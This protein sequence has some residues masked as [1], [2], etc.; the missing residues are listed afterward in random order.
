METRG[1]FLFKM[2]I[3]VLMIAAA[4]MALAVIDDNQFEEVSEAAGVSYIGPSWGSMWGDF[5]GDGFADVW[6]INHYNQ[7][8]LF[9]NLG[10][11]TF[12]DI[13]E[14]VMPEGLGFGDTHG[15]AW[16]DFDNDGDQ[17]LYQLADGGLETAPARLMVNMGGY[18]EDMGQE[19]GLDY[20]LGRGRMPNWLDFNRDGLLDMLHATSPRINDWPTAL[21]QQDYLDIPGFTEV[22]DIM[23]LDLEIKSN[24][25][26]QMADVTGDGN[27]DLLVQQSGFPARIYDISVDPFEDIQS[28]VGLSK[29]AVVV[30]AAIGDLDGDLDNDMFMVRGEIP[31]GFAQIDDFTVEARLI[32]VYDNVERGISFKT[33]GDVSIGV[34]P[35]WDWTVNKIFI[36]SS[37]MHPA[38]LQ[39]TLSPTDPNVIGIYD[40]VPASDTNL[41]IGY[42]PGTQTW[43][44][45]R[46]E[47]LLDLV[48]ESTL[49]ISEVS[50][51]GFD[52]EELPEN[53]P[54]DG[55][56]RYG[57][58]GPNSQLGIFGAEFGTQRCGR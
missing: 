17:D 29:V 42:D 32:P 19:Y 38:A 50:A 33:T 56:R 27:L 35:V 5:N 28:E 1:V 41:Y 46:W 26:N 9:F 53:G 10:D 8:S 4:G 57:L 34:W 30:D 15:A 45:Y 54:I 52:P 36:G 43:Q 18:F 44:A 16:A 23:G 55:Q 58:C 31:Y 20:P 47:K 6:V 14:G 25:F 21:F 51:I 7:I 13:Y 24:D 3:V 39:F 11:G 22:T 37:G 49:T 40:H 2:G 12:I 48:V